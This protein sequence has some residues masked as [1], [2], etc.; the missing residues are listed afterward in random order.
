VYCILSQG[1]DYFNVTNAVKKGAVPTEEPKMAS[2]YSGD[3]K[4]IAVDE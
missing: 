4:Y 3:V 2:G 1:I